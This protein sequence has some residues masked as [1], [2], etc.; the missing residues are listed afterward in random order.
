MKYVL[1]RPEC[2]A[3]RLSACAGIYTCNADSLRKTSVVIIVDTVVRF[4]A[5]LHTSARRRAC[6]CI[7]VGIALR[8]KTLTAGFRRALCTLPLHL[9]IAL[10][11]TLALIVKTIF[12]RT[13]K[14]RYHIE[15][16]SAHFASA[17]S[18]K[19]SFLLSAIKGV[20]FIR[21]SEVRSSFYFCSSCCISSRRSLPEIS[22][23]TASTKSPK[24]FWPSS[25]AKRL[26]T[27]TRPL[28]SSF[29]PTTSI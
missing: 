29:C 18:D 17:F 28:S 2:A 1:S 14:Y 22:F 19:L 23:L 20:P 3:L 4:T 6:V 26:L 7:A 15:L 25:P 5:N 16:P 12:C 9:D 8:L 11:A 10:A 13:F 21:N 27:E 24:A